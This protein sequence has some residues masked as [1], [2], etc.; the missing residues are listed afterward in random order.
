MTHD[1][2]D[3]LRMNFKALMNNILL[4]ALVFCVALCFIVSVAILSKFV[5][6]KAVLT[7]YIIYWYTE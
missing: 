5:H 7:L 6:F 3:K 2:I 1:Y 4:E